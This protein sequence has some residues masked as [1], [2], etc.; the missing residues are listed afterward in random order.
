MHST[1]KKWGEAEM[2]S[3]P[4]DVSTREDQ[5][6]L[7]VAEEVTPETKELTETLLLKYWHESFV[8]EGYANRMD[9]D[10]QRNRGAALLANFF[11][12]WQ[13]EPR[14]V[15]IVEKG[16]KVTLPSSQHVL[17]GRFDRVERTAGGLRIIDFKTGAPRDQIAVDADVQL[18]LYAMAAQN[19]WDEPVVE[20]SLLFFGDDGMIERKTTRNTSQLIDAEKSMKHILERIEAGDY[21]PDPAYEKCKRC[22]FKGVCPASAA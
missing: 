21:T 6:K 9:A 2:L 7:F 22:P 14:E 5:L 20:L 13:E 18:S 1:L 4:K 17:T 8:F 16:F 10:F 12:W 15:L 19:M 11:Q 3:R